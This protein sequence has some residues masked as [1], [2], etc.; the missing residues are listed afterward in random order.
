MFFDNLTDNFEKPESR[1]HRIL[2]MNVYALTGYIITEILAFLA[3]M[4]GFS[5]ISFP[6]LFTLA[7]IVNAVTI[8]N[9]IVI[10]RIPVITRNTEV[11]LFASA[12]I[13]N[14]IVF[15]FALYYARE[16]RI[17]GLAFALIAVIIEMPFITFI[18]SALISIGSIADMVAV[19][20]FAIHIKGQPGSFSHEMFF[21]LAFLPAFLL[22]SLIAKQINN[23]KRI[24]NRDRADLERVNAKLNEANAR[25]NRTQTMSKRDLEI[26]SAVQSS[27][28]PELPDS[29]EDWDIQICFLPRYS[30]SGDF[31]DFFFNEG[32]LNGMTIYDV[33]GHGVS[34]A[35][36]TMIIKPT[37]FRTF[38]KMQNENL[39]K[40]VSR[41]NEKLSAEFSKLDH[42]LTGI[43]LR[44][45][46]DSIEYINAGHPDMLIRR[47]D[48]STECAGTCDGYEKGEPLGI[49][50][51]YQTHPF[52]K[53]DIHKGDTLVLYTDCLIE[54][55]DSD[56]NIY[57]EK[58]LHAL[59]ESIPDG[60]AHHF[61][62]HIL[63][64]F[65]SF[66]SG[67][68]LH[69]DLTVIVLQKK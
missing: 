25:L 62:A 44:F 13:L 52:Y 45:K 64:D 15:A 17:Y 3:H 33:S 34:S 59:I 46:E 2:I 11:V 66:T 27:F 67:M 26:A 9:I 10:R 22:L 53:I 35:L 60:S 36:L 48:G 51:D 28:L 20:W 56:Q 12:Y 39:I 21:S 6:E 63:E 68:P 16:M 50:N 61:L 42:Y 58:R 29:I 32:R 31:F 24:I 30:V 54:S 57:G 69:D 49:R 65:F 55:A 4:F 18:E 38:T 23:H 37:I 40:I 14:I 47:A 43:I 41:I 8:I 5:S 19:S 1:A 7:F